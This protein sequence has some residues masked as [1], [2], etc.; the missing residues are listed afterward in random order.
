MNN[1]IE[2]LKK[3]SLPLF[4][5]HLFLI[6]TGSLWPRLSRHYQKGEISSGQMPKEGDNFKMVNGPIVYRLE[7]GKRR[8]YK[9]EQAFFNTIGNKPF[10][11]PYEQ[12]GILICDKVVVLALAIG[13][14]MP[15]KAGGQGEAYT[16]KG[17][18]EQLK[19]GIFRIDKMGHFF[20]YTV[21]AILLLIV[22]ERYRRPY[23]MIKHL[24]VL[25][26][27]II[28]GGVIEQ[29]QFEYVP[30]RNKELLDLLF[31]TLGVLVGIWIYKRWFFCP[32][33]GTPSIKMLEKQ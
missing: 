29:L 27:G 16:P 26:F 28:F 4:A 18:W 11:T 10:D 9:S 23:F 1:S 19:R 6:V 13:N 31:N 3:Y 7:D 32:N 12:G 20:A 8:P 14:Y 30:G 2:V 5:L 17:T 22:L 25:V 15:K 24:F 21:L 33:E